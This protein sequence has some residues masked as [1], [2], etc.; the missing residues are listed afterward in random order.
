MS[1]VDSCAQSFDANGSSQQIKQQI[2]SKMKNLLINQIF[3]IDS[4]L[5]KSPKTQ[6]HFGDVYLRQ[7]SLVD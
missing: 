6:Q 7:L 3:R 1:E 4:M 5:T 2:T